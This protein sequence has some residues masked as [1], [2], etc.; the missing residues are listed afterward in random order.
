MTGYVRTEYPQWSWSHSRQQLFASCPRRYYYNYYA[1]HNGWEFNAPSEAALTYRL[2]KLSNLYLVL[3][4]AVHKVA[5]Q[6]VENVS[7]G[8]SLWDADT[9]EEEIRRNLRRVW[10]SSRDDLDQFIRRPNRVDML[11][12]F[13]YQM[14]V[15]ETVVARINKRTTQ[16]AKALV[17][18]PVWDLL[19]QPNVELISYEQFDTFLIDDTPVYAVPDLL[20]KNP[21]GEWIIVD[22]KTGEEVDDNRD[23]VALYALFVH[24]KYGVQIDQIRAR[25]EY[26]NLDQTTEMQFTG[27]DL[28]EVK[29]TA[30]GSIAEMQKLLSDPVQNIP[31]GKEHFVLT[32]SRD[33]CPWCNFYELCQEELKRSVS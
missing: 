29:A 3:G 4:D 7:K 9:V 8:R 23:Q 25:L 17:A 22:W 5:A 30:R 13:Y 28:E 16:T 20:Y 18:S 14:G 32:D 10:K 31:K 6:M 33:R 11:H 21:Q 12:E 24:E 27:E 2:K 26:L 19:A 15:S 1:S